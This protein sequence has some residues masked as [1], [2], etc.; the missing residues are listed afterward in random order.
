[1]NI[2]LKP[3]LDID[4]CSIAWELKVLGWE[5]SRRLDSDELL[6]YA[7]DESFFIGTICEGEG[8]F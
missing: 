4:N 7:A 3:Y 2:P 8:L 1:M 6:V 5:S